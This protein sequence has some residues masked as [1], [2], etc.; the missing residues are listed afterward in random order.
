MNKLQA[1]FGRVNV[2]PMM[3]VY[4][5]GYFVPRYVEGVLD[6]LEINAIA[7][8]CGDDKAVLISLDNLGIK[9]DARSFFPTLSK[10]SSK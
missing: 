6:E 8:A 2:T 1:G 10:L 7:L 9:V 3:G 5:D 4:M